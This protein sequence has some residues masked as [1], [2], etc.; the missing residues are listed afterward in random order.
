MN[1]NSHSE[2]QQIGTTD[3]LNSYINLKEM[4]LKEN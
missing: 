4:N 2:L 3:T 1:E